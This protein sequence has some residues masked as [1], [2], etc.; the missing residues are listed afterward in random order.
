[1]EHKRLNA[2]LFTE[3]IQKDRV[4]FKTE[5]DHELN[6]SAKVRVGPNKS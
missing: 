6:D 1:M 2:L 5:K 3:I 4:I